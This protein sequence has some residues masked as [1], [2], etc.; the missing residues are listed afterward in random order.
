MSGQFHSFSQSVDSKY[1]NVFHRKVL[2][3]KVIR[4]H[5][6]SDDE[7]G[8]MDSNKRN[9]WWF[10][11]SITYEYKTWDIEVKP[12]LA[13]PKKA[14]RAMA[15]KPPELVNKFGSQISAKGRNY[16]RSHAFNKAINNRRS[17]SRKAF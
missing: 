16:G 14:R 8:W 2:T 1:E 11:D 12:H 6:T 4:N 5:D 9:D 7:L 3:E 15:D 17:F 13:M 10:T